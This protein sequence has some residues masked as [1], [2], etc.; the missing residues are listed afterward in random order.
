MLKIKKDDEIVVISGRDKGKRGDVLRVLDDERL[1]VG[2]VNMVKK[3][4]R[5]NPNVGQQGG[6]IEQEAPIQASNV[7]IW[8]SDEDKADRV[9]FRVEDDGA[10]V[11]F[12][13]STGK[14][15]EE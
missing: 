5:P 11:R 10:K 3:H 7:A 1:L 9:G 14:V 8:N 2:G 12:Y 15:I 6:I 4:Q 13:K